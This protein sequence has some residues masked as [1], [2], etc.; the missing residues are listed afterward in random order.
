ME[1]KNIEKILEEEDVD[2]NKQKG[3]QTKLKIEKI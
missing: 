2:Y 1:Q 3:N